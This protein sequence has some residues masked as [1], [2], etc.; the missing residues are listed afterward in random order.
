MCPQGYRRFESHP[1]RV[2]GCWLRFGA[3]QPAL[4][5]LLLAAVSEC[6]G[7]GARRPRSRPD[8]AR[9][10]ADGS[11]DAPSVASRYQLADSDLVVAG[12]G[13]ATDSTQAVRALGSP[14]S[15]RAYRLYNDGELP[16]VDWEFHD[17]TLTFRSGSLFMARITGRSVPTRRGLRIGDPAERVVE[18]YA[19]PRQSHSDATRWLFARSTAPSNWQGMVVRLGGGV[20]KEIIVGTVIYGD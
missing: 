7:E 19:W 6:G 4:A 17:L 2:N 8:G 10:V 15:T 9:P 20:V 18:L 13:P 11:P 3:A 16:V 1:V 5:L 12:L 14:R